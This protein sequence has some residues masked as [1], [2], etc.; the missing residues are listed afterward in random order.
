MAEEKFVTISLSRKQ[1]DEK[2]PHHNEKNGKDYLRI[3][4]PGGG[5]IFYP[6]DSIKV[7]KNDPEKVYFSRPEGTEFFINYSERLEDV[8]D[9]APEEQ[10]YY[11]YQKTVKIED[12]K[13]M[14]EEERRAYAEKNAAFV[15]MEVPTEW[16]EPFVSKE[17]KAL[18]SISIPVAEGEERH[19][20]NFIVAAE[21]FRESTKNENMS[22]FGFP[23]KKKDEEAD[24]MVTLKRS[25]KQ[26]NGDYV[27]ITKEISSTELAEHVEAA[28]RTYSF[29]NVE[30]SN[31]LIREFET[32]D[33]VALV[34][35]SVPVYNQESNKE[36]FY[37]IVVNPARIR[38][39]DENNVRLSMFRKG[40]SGDDYVFHAKR[41]VLDEA[42]QEYHD[43]TKDITSAEVAKCFADSRT[44][45]REQG[46]QSDHSLGD[47]MRQNATSQGGQEEP[48]FRQQMRRGGR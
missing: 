31:K 38:E 14:Y 24:Y 46:M 22:Y 1:V 42:T 3:Y 27:D 19:Y 17:G 41:S 8:P 37:Q 18:V 6:A 10:K 4:A 5:V 40:S 15:N 34:S 47:E 43:V 25:E 7:H 48:G 32:K 21:A 12:L 13:E 11:N 9:N 23:K 39:V 16:G 28:K 30:I 26:E 45:F 44:R 29:I 20:Y 2:N 35:V 36:E 33:N